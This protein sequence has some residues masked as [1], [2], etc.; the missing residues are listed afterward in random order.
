MNKCKIFII[1]LFILFT[2]FI[3]V[4]DSIK[5]EID[6]LIANTDPNINIGVKIVRLN[7]NKI[8]YEKNIDSFYNFAS[9]LKVLLTAS[10]I[11]FFGEDYNF[12]NSIARFGEDYYLDIGD[13][14]NFTEKD[15]DLLIQKLKAQNINSIN[16]NFYIVKK[17][18]KLE[19]LSPYKVIV[20]SLYC[21]GAPVS[22]T[23]INKNCFQLA[24]SPGKV[25]EEL[26]LSTQYP[27]LFKIN[28]E[29]KTIRDKSTKPRIQRF[30][31]GDK[32][33]VIGTLNE[34]SNSISINPVI[35]DSIKYLS[36]FLEYTLKS[37]DIKLK[38]KIL[39]FINIT[40]SKATLIAE[41]KKD[42]KE[43]Y[44]TILKKSDNYLSD[45]LFQLISTNSIYDEWFE[46]G[47]YLRQYAATRFKI[48]LDHAIIMDGSGMSRLNMLTP[49]QMSNLLSAIY[50]KPYFNNFKNYLAQPEE[51]STLKERFKDFPHK[52]FAKT[53]SMRGIYS[54]VGYLE[55]DQNIYSFVIVVNNAVVAKENYIK[56]KE[57]IINTIK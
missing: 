11:E 35:E 9:S 41:N 38:G 18:F 44:K 27:N 28:N 33:K 48:S 53:G 15:L 45:Y 57:A 40:S 29:A 14:P 39:P 26:K 30:V 36:L 52:I 20:D 2:S 50:R 55:K 37:N 22:R 10:A 42:I 32:I 21:Y 5:Y 23:H 46:A 47:D 49:N 17:D 7:D 25:G 3:A 31:N 4:A 24:A 13:D 43:I 51:D 56:L 19:S 8:L 16:G 54:L 6:K 12:K 1:S 34:S